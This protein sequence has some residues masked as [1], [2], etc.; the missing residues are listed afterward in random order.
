MKLKDYEN[1]L[2]R[3]YKGILQ[4]KIY[5]ECLFN[6]QIKENIATR[7]EIRSGKWFKNYVV[8]ISTSFYYKQNFKKLINNLIA[9]FL[10]LLKNK[11]ENSNVRI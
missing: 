3:K 8:D 11:E 6:I 5:D 9:D 7:I 2:N 4:I 10:K 1:E